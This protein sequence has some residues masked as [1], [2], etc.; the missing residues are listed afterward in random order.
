MMFFLFSF[1]RLSD[2]NQIRGMTLSYIYF[3]ISQSKIPVQPFQELLVVFWTIL[4]ILYKNFG[5][6]PLKL[7]ILLIWFMNYVRIMI[8]STQFLGL[9]CRTKPES[10]ISTF[11][12]VKQLFFDLNCQTKSSWTSHQYSVLVILKLNLGILKK[13]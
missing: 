9:I 2:M 5:K 10:N 13:F 3:I 6:K 7:V 1:T 8:C 4:V 12:V 11:L